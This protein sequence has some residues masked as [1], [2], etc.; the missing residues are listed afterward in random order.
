MS[1]PADPRWN[2]DT[3]RGLLH[4]GVLTVLA[5]TTCGGAVG[6]AL[7]KPTTLATLDLRMDYLRAPLAG[8]DVVCVGDCY[9]I[10]RSVAFARGLLTQDDPTRPV[11]EIQATFM[12]NT[13]SGPRRAEATTIEAGID[14][15]MVAAPPAPQ[16]WQAPGSDA[17]IPLDREVPYAGYLGIRVVREPDRLLFRMPYRDDLVGNPN[18]PALHGGVVAAFAESSALLHLVL[19]LDGSRYPK[20]I[21]FSADYLRPGRPL[22]TWAQCDIVRLGSRVALVQIRCW[23]TDPASPVLVARGHYLLSDDPARAPAKAP[24]G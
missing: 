10:T 22:D 8:Q 17:P 18:L 3:E 24:E 20:G 13:P 7:K 2:V 12:L 16:G 21:D 9:R 5:D 4:P 6:F 23:Q 15:R 19:A 14:P 11:A 1:L